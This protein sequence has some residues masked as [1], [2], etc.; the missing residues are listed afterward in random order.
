MI[1]ATD[2]SV[3]SGRILES[4]PKKD[5]SLPSRLATKPASEKA[6]VSVTSSSF[7]PSRASTLFSR[8]VFVFVFV[9]FAAVCVKVL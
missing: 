7:V 1:S 5:C 9:L 4:S 3:V 2:L 8:F 6:T